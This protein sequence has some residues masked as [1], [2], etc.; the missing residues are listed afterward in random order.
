MRMSAPFMCDASS[1]AMKAMAA[2]MPSGVPKAPSGMTRWISLASAP[3]GTWN[4][5][6]MGVSMAPGLTLL[7]RTPAL[8]YST[9]SSRVMASTPPLEAV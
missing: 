4:A 5:D 6:V 8:A 9:A 7:Q 3:S 2:A 1:E